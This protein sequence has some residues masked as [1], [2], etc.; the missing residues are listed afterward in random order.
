MYGL[1]RARL[2]NGGLSA[3]ID[4]YGVRRGRGNVPRMQARL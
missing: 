3:A 2:A 4:E 1:L